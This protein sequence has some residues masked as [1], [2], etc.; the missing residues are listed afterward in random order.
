MVLLLGS[1]LKCPI[2]VGKLQFQIPQK[3]V[4]YLGMKAFLDLWVYL[5]IIFYFTLETLK[6][7]R[8]VKMGEDYIFSHGLFE[9]SLHFDYLLTTYG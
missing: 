5:E 3:Q 7:I 6:Q 1:L 4:C 8:F 9:V 2:Q